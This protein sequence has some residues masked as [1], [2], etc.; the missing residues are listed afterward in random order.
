MTS[1]TTP[2]IPGLLYIDDF[3]TE[4]EEISLVGGISSHPTAWKTLANRRLQ[5]WGGLPH[6]KGML[7]TPLP[8]FL[9]PLLTKL[10]TSEEL[11]QH[12][13]EQAWRPNHVLINR[14]L[15]GEGIDAHVDGPAYQP[16]ATI[17]SMCNPIVM[18]FFKP[19]SDG[20]TVDLD[21]CIASVLLRRRSLLVLSQE[22]YFDFYHSIS[23]RKQDILDASVVLNL[24]AGEDGTVLERGERMS[25][26]VRAACRTI[27]NSMLGRRRG[28]CR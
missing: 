17:T 9:N 15:P 27:S 16:V 7:P 14:Y 4:A 28:G 23:K 1:F 12:T 2:L 6:I 8:P 26:T 10:R 18:D 22:A 20:D 25:L 3:I 21:N 5:N 13:G 11:A 24:C 19:R